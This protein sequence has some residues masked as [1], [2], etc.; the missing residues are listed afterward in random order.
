MVWQNG[1]IHPEKKGRGREQKKAIY[2]QAH[3]VHAGSQSIVIGDYGK[4]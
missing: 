2:R 1:L 3:A 4:L